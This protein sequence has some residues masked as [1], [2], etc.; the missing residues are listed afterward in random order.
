MN[1][2]KSLTRIIPIVLSVILLITSLV[3]AYLYYSGLP[4]VDKESAAQ[5]ENIDDEMIF[6]SEDIKVRV[7]DVLEGEAK[8]HFCTGEC[9]LDLEVT[10]NRDSFIVEDVLIFHAIQGIKPV[11]FNYSYDNF[12]YYILRYG[13]GNESGTY[14]LNNEGYISKSFC[15]VDNESYES[16]ILL[17]DRNLI[18]NDCEGTS[19]Y[20]EYLGGISMINLDTGDVKTIVEPV[21]GEAEKSYHISRFNK[22]KNTLDTKECI[23]TTDTYGCED[24]V[25]DI[26]EI[27]K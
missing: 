20:G 7:K 10:Y 15:S 21:P 3:F 18:F 19:R 24:K 2:N 17:N 5:D 22:G 9:K 4:E 13:S 1:E 23:T 25:I 14:V 26:S 6:Y 8:E 27:L 16:S 11:L 12:S